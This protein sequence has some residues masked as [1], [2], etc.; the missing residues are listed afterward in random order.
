MATR[1][2]RSRCVFAVLLLGT[3]SCEGDK[4]P[5]ESEASLIPCAGAT[6]ELASIG[7]KRV[8]VLDVAGLLRVPLKWPEPRGRQGD[9]GTRTEG[10]TFIKFGLFVRSDRDVRLGVESDDQT[11][12]LMEWGGVEP[13]EQLKVGPCPTES[14]N[15]LAFAGGVWIS[16]PACLDLVVSSRSSTVRH[17]LDIGSKC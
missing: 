10:L 13:A 15:W 2:I 7:D 6:D 3:T 8:E 4:V 11:M 14:H 16:E 5:P 17:P 12:V 9:S 1:T